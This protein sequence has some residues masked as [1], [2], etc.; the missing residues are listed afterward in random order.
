M[1]KFLEQ[2]SFP[3]TE[4]EYDEQLDAVAEYLNAWGMVDRQVG[5]TYTYTCSCNR[6][7]TSSALTT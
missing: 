5:C 2:K 1:W 6:F 4:A 3:L 7:D